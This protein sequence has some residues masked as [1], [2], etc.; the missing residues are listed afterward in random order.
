MR[1][2]QRLGQL[3]A[4]V[5][6]A[7]KPTKLPSYGDAFFWGVVSA[8]CFCLFLAIQ[9]SNWESQVHESGE[10]QAVQAVLTFATVVGW[11]HTLRWARGLAKAQRTQAKEQG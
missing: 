11:L 4:R 8:L 2:W 6:G 1:V 3:D 9:L 10:F 7:I 5:L